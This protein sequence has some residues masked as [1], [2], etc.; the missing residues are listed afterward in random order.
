MMTPETRARL[1]AVEQQLAA[2]TPRPL[3]GQTALPIRPSGAAPMPHRVQRRR[4]KGWRKPADCVI[5]DR[6]SRF[7]N[8]FGIADAVRDFGYTRDEARAHV[9]AAFRSWLSGHR[10]HWL[11]DEGDRARERIL[12]GLD[13]L[14]GKDLACVCALDEKCH[15]DVLLEWAAAPDLPRRVADARAQVDA[16]RTEHGEEPLYGA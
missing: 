15:A 14:A 5:V 12:A 2:P 3:T 6:T 8:P 10:D 4:T 11:G 9:V 16:S 7:G 1:L 13:E